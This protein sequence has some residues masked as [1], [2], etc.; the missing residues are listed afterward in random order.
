MLSNIVQGH[1]KICMSTVFDMY[2]RAVR[3][4][5]L[6]WSAKNE[7]FKSS[8]SNRQVLGQ[9]GGA[10]CHFWG[11][12]RALLHLVHTKIKPRQ[13]KRTSKHGNLWKTDEF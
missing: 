2:S 1:L 10:G 5:V 3:R 7:R 4:L 12:T 8:C 13:E 6:A 9:I 11:W